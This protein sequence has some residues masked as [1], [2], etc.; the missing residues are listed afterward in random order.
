MRISAKADYALRAM[1]ELAGAEPDRPV[2]AEAIATRQDVPHKFLLAILSELKRAH[3]VRSQRGADGGFMLSRDPREIT[4]ADVYRAIEGPLADVHDA[5]LRDLSYN[6][7]AAPMKEIWMA[8]RGSLRNVL[9]AVTLADLVAGK[10]PRSVRGLAEAYR[11][12]TEG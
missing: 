3:L 11:H 6:G 12:A 8:V 10:L 1:A 4:L 2:K 7:A 9:E 5:S